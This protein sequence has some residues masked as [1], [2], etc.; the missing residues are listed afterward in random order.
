MEVVRHKAFRFH[1]YP[2]LSQVARLNAWSDAL[3]FLWN[4]A[5]EAI[6]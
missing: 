4:L 3:R 1:V 2:S 6:Q 5:L